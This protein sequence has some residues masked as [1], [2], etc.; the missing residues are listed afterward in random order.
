MHRHD[1]GQIE[2]LI[3]NNKAWVAKT[4]AEDPDFFTDLA[5]AHV[6]AFLWIGCSDARVQPNILVNL[7]QGEIFTHRNLGNM[8]H[9]SDMNI[10]AVVQ[11]AVEVLQVKHIIVAGHEDCGAIKAAM[12]DLHSDVLQQWLH[13]IRTLYYAHKSQLIQLDDK[14]QV[15]DLAKLNINQQ[16]TNLCNMA[17]IRS[18]WK[19]GQNLVIHGWMLHLSTG[20]IEDL[21]LSVKNLTEANQ[22]LGM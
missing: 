4:L 7:P 17:A 10:T 18:A 16:V 20:L 19:Q 15:N 12:E 13:P 11:Y 21:G 5:K 1:T 9:S 8:V 3:E 22:R 6:P 2:Q 14:A